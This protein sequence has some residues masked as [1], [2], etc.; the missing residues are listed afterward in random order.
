M[1]KLFIPLIILLISGLIVLNYLA[2][3]SP[4]IKKMV[5]Q[6]TIYQTSNDKLNIALYSNYQGPYQTLTAIESVYLIEDSKRL[7]VMLTEINKS[8]DYKYLKETFYK[9]VYTLTLPIL[10]N[11]YYMNE[12]YVEINLKMV[13]VKHFY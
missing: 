6:R 1:K 13:K 2:Y 9:Y 11:H 7:E 5:S 12:A 4:K 8:Y 10:E 3:K